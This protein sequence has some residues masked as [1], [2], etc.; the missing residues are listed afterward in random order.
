MEDGNVVWFA[1]PPF[2]AR[3]NSYYYVLESVM[4]GSGVAG[5]PTLTPAF[6]STPFPSLPPRP[7]PHH[8]C[9]RPCLTESLH[10]PTLSYTF[11]QLVQVS[12]LFLAPRLYH[13]E[14]FLFTYTY[15]LE[16]FLHTYTRTYHQQSLL[17]TYT[18]KNLSLPYTVA[19]AYLILFIL[20]STRTFF[21]S[22]L[23]CSLP[24][25]FSLSEHCSTL[26]GGGN[27]LE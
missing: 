4:C 26:A 19:V 12:T 21:F 6:H 7:P 13:L 16:L 11:S 18:I 2:R 15:R 23:H 14:S 9:V 5:S 10:S 27:S 24:A 25:R 20:R 3:N 22:F 8:S 1:S 17:H